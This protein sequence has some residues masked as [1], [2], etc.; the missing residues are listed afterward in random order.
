MRFRYLL[1]LP[2][3]ALLVA[4][5]GTSADVSI[6]KIAYQNDPAP[7]TSGG[8]YTQFLGGFGIGSPVLDNAGSVA[9]RAF[10]G[11]GSPSNDTATFAGPPGVVRL[12]ARE[13]S[14]LL[15]Q[16][17][18]FG[19]NSDNGRGF[20]L[21]SGSRV[22]MMGPTNSG[23]DVIVGA[24]GA[25]AT[26]ARIGGQAATLPAGVQYGSFANLAYGASGQ[27]AFVV[28]LNG[29]A[30]T[31]RRALYADHLGPL[32][33]WLIQN[34]AAPGL[35]GQS[36]TTIGGISFNTAGRLA[37]K[38]GISSGGAVYTDHSGALSPVAWTG[39]S[40]PGA[41]TLSTIPE[42]AVAP[43]FNSS[44]RVAFR[45]F[46]TSGNAGHFSDRSGTMQILAFQG[47]AIPGVA[48][49]QFNSLATT[50][51]PVLNN[52]GDVAFACE[53]WFSGVN[54][55]LVFISR[56]GGGQMVAREG[57]PT[58]IGGGVNFAA[59][60]YA[61]VR[62]NN[63]GQLAFVSSLAGSG[64]NSSNDRALFATESATGPLVAV[65]REGQVIDVHGDGSVLRTVGAFEFSIPND[66]RHD[67]WSGIASGAGA[68]NDFGTLAFQIN[69][70]DG[71]QG[72]FA[73]T[74]APAP[75]CDPDVNGDGAVNSFDIAC[76][77][78]AVNGDF[79]CYT[80]G[81]ADFNQDGAENGFDVEAVEQV[82]NGAPCP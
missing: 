29:G 36:I 78:M 45:S 70:T 60:D 24:T 33:P 2:A 53:G 63:A 46:L 37:C 47:M 35:S 28:S 81:S 17:G 23:V 43:S 38:I 8:W 27:V 22:A 75:T 15:G 56:P 7:D 64:V 39:M 72:V 54:Y 12:W 65:L 4:A 57:L 13:G 31:F 82:V 62:L 14:T 51:Q 34:N 10:V 41:G 19:H 11:G 68:F 59:I 79:S 71:T 49:S 48:G 16:G 58:P 69:F 52:G 50:P 40:V 66:T 74:V 55:D 77:E 32:T 73:A 67:P 21:I 44:G 76:Q 42:I 9:F 61:S 5:S 3:A 30:Y 6:V 26:Y 1:G 18:T 80:Q 25:A 20:P